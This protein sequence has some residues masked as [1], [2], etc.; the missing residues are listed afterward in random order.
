VRDPRGRYVL[1][2][3]DE[4]GGGVCCE[5]ERGCV[6]AVR[7]VCDFGKWFTKNLGINCFPK[8]CTAFSGQHKSF[9]VD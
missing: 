2:E 9:A 5:R 1:C 3:I 6:C 7:E 8:F 4:G